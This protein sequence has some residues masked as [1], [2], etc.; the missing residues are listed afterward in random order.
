[1]NEKIGENASMEPGT[2]LGDG[3]QA[4]RKF[5]ESARSLAPVF[6]LGSG[7]CGTKLLFS[8]L[9]SAGGFAITHAESNAYNLLGLC[10]GSLAKRH[11]RRRLLDAYLASHIFRESGLVPE[12]I[13]GSVMANCRNTGDF[14]RIV[15]E[16]ITQKQGAR[17]WAES[18]PWHLHYLPLIKKEIPNALIIHIIRDGRDVTASLQRADMF[19]PMPWDRKRALIARAIYWRW[20]V[21]KGRRYGQTLGGDYMEVRYE[22]LVERPR[23]TLALVGRFIDHDLDYDKIRQVAFG[24][25]DVPNTS[26]RGDGK[27]SVASP[28]GRWR[29]VFTPHQ[30][31]DIEAVLEDALPQHGY[32]LQTPN[33]ERRRSLAVRYMTVMHPLYLNLRVWLKSNTPLARFA[34]KGY[35]RYSPATPRVECQEQENVTLSS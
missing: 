25:V 13:S 7:R 11:N 10:F 9:L 29:R 8:A 15:M 35:L 12:D 22:D 24:M 2:A 33:A 30:L 19:G 4:S 26:F 3:Q 28:V 18:T 27:E 23:E 16:A 1:M 17:R 34:R 20:I 32:A 31:R 14:L 5:G 21:N 6:V